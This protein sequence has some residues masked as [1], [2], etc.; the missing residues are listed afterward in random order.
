MADLTREEL[1]MSG[2]YRF[3]FV[4]GPHDGMVV[5]GDTLVAPRLQLPIQPG[6]VAGTAAKIPAALYEVSAKALRWEEGAPQAV[7]RY[8]FRGSSEG[9]SPGGLKRWL[10]DRR[11]RV[12]R[13]MMAPVGYPMSTRSE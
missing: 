6:S 10:E 9:N 12:A 8:E 13:W 1:K 4:R 11:H 3:E 7:L 5:E 2:F